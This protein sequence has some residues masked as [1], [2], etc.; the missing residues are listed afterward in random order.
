MIRIM[1]GPIRA[2][3]TPADRQGFRPVDLR[4]S[5]FDA[6]FGI[7]D[8]FLCR[9]RYRE[10]EPAAVFGILTWDYTGTDPNHREMDIELTK[11]GD[12]TI[13]NAQFVLQPYVANRDKSI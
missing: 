6:Q 8:I 13:K 3:I 1:L 5:Q 7:R 11:W 2:G 9:P 10:L 4:G 12:S